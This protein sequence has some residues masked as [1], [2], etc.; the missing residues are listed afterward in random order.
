MSIL[1]KRLSKIEAELLVVAQPIKFMFITTC[2]H[3]DDSDIL[4]YKSGWGSLEVMRLQ[5]ESIE[6]LK[7]RTQ[8]IFIESETRNT[9]IFILRCI[10]ENKP[11]ARP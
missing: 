11:M 8:K 10:Y 4:G 1:S 6:D 7:E 2:G 5:N 9:P 3:N